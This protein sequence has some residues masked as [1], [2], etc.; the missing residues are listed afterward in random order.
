MAEIPEWLRRKLQQ[1][2]ERAQLEAKLD[3]QVRAGEI[4][5]EEADMEWYD[6]THRGEDRRA[7]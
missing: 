6:F 7:L 5:A 1:S 3:R 2:S 4:T